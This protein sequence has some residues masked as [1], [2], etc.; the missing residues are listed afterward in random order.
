M[1]SGWNYLRDQQSV[2]FR[3]NVDKNTLAKP[4]NNQLLNAMYIF[5]PSGQ[6]KQQ[7]W[8][9]KYIRFIIGTPMSSCICSLLSCSFS[10]SRHH[11]I[12]LLPVIQIGTSRVIPYRN[13]IHRIHFLYSD[14]LYAIG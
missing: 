7:S 5:Q 11:R 4:M 1:W 10:F 14:K 8:K 13:A 3:F 12:R 2:P 9:I 6:A